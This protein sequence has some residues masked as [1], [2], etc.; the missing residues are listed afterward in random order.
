MNVFIPHP[1]WPGSG[2][3]MRS[4]NRWPR[5]RGDKANRYPLYLCYVATRIRDAGG[6]VRFADA[7]MEGLDEK[8][9]IARI[10]RHRPGLLYLE[11]CTPT[12]NYDLVFLGRVKDAV[13]GCTTVLAGSH[14][15]YF[16]DRI[17]RDF[18]QVDAIVRGEQDETA[19]AIYEA[20][21]GGGSIAGLPGTVARDAE[22]RPLRGPARPLISDLDALPFPDRDLIPHSWYREG[23]VVRTP[24]TFAITSR[25]CP[26]ACRFCLWPNVFFEHKVR[27]RSIENV[28]AEVDWLVSR[29]GM[30]ELFFDD[31]TFNVGERRTIEFCEALAARGHDLQWG[32]SCR[33]SPVSREMLAA[34]KRAGCRLICYG[35]ESANQR[36][37]DRCRKGISVEMFEPA[38]RLTQEAGIA[39]HANFMLGFP[40]E[41][42]AEM[43]N[44]IATAIRLAPDTA[45]FS[46]V[47][48]HPGSAM[49]DEALQ[50]GWLLDGVE[51]DWD[52]FEMSLGPVLKTPMSHRAMLGA[53]RR[54]HAR[55]YARPGH[56]LRLLM[57]VR[58]ADDLRRLFRGAWSV[59]TGKILF[60]STRRAPSASRPAALRTE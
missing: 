59:F 37:L 45:Q 47:F 51:D 50:E 2:Y 33:V 40:W 27:F 48:P 16:A 49:Y 36:T 43:E 57:K 18:P 17:L 15:T 52:R 4:Q 1:P 14:A 34:M 10:A 38:I 56:A 42:P 8:E 7:V 39:A 41:T 46:L 19:L 24:F 23:H 12:A 55:F 11:T 9:L 13:P 21:A 35:P 6:D 32:C 28:I 29:Y 30:R 20:L 58:S 53:I 54:A 3:G 26:N 60:R 25:G 22:G 44:T 5:K 31:G